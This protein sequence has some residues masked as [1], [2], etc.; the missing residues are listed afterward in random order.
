M[1]RDSLTE[2]ELGPEQLDLPGR[3]FESIELKFFDAVFEQ[4]RNPSLRFILLDREELTGKPIARYAVCEDL[5]L[6]LRHGMG[7]YI[8]MS[9]PVKEDAEDPYRSDLGPENTDRHVVIS[10]RRG[11][12]YEG[13]SVNN[14]KI[15]NFGR[16]ETEP[17]LS[18]RS[19]Q[20]LSPTQRVEELIS[21]IQTFPVA[22]L[23]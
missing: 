11:D 22:P 14:F 2:H 23:R 21:K 9:L 20:P 15:D 7:Q 12:L 10:M 4:R 13:L 18:D 16:G 19:E 6:L 8:E 1:R 3:L 5:E 17:P